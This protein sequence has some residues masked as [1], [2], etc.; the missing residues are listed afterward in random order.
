MY[1][2]YLFEAV[3]ISHDLTLEKKGL[4]CMIRFGCDGFDPFPFWSVHY[5]DEGY[6]GYST[7][8]VSK[9]DF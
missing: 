2:L 3:Y 7:A 6:R 9:Q 1:I 4:E 5:G 8:V